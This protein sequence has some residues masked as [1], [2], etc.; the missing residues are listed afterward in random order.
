MRND[1]AL[2]VIIIVLAAVLIVVIGAARYNRTTKSETKCTPMSH[3][4]ASNYTTIIIDSCECIE[5]FN[6]LAHK[7]NCKFCAERHRNEI[8]DLV[9]QFNKQ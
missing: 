8:Y 9:K 1:F 5:A 4:A 6:K 7:G 3:G 2:T